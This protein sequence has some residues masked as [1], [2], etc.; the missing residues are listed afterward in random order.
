MADALSIAASIAGVVQ[1]SVV[2]FQSI[3][4]FIKDAKDARAKIK[5]LAT[6]TRNLSGVLQ[7]LSLLASSF[8]DQETAVSFRA[9]HIHACLS[10]LR[11]IDAGLRRAQDDLESGKKTRLVSRSLK[12][13]F[14]ADETKELVAELTQNRA[15]LELALTAD[16]MA[17]LLQSL[18]VSRAIQESVRVLQEAFRRRLAIEKRV[19]LDLQRRKIVDYFLQV[20]PQPNFQTCLDLRQPNTGRWL[21]ERNPSYLH[22]K[23]V[24]NSKI[25]L[26]G[27]PGEC[28]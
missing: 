21:T 27:I 23:S 12:W 3:T 13:P 28:Y 11:K 2:V 25:W 15:N 1:L 16:S 8:D 4:L 17:M 10:T 22:W 6:Q 9:D 5:E 14:A 7:N 20:N 18:S 26:S 24:P 19:E